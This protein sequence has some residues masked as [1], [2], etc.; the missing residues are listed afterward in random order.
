MQWPAKPR[1]AVRF[2]SWPPLEVVATFARKF[3]IKHSCATKRI[4]RVGLSAVWLSSEIV[5]RYAGSAD[6][7]KERDDPTGRRQALGI[8]RHINNEGGQDVGKF[9]TGMMSGLLAV[10]TAIGL[11]API[12]AQVATTSITGG[13]SQTTLPEGTSG[14][15]VLGAAGIGFAGG[16]IIVDGTLNVVSPG[17]QSPTVTLTLYDVGSESHWVNQIRLGNTTGAV[18]TDDD[19]HQREGGG[20]TGPFT[21]AP[22]ARI[23]TVTQGAGVAELEFWGSELPP[24]TLIVE[25]G[26][27]PKQTTGDQPTSIALAYLNDSYQIVAGPTERIL[28][29]LEDGGADRDYDDYVGILEVAAGSSAPWGTVGLR[30]EARPVSQ[31]I[32]AFVSVTAANGL[33]ISGLTAADITLLADGSALSSPPTLVLP[34]AQSSEHLSVVFAMDYSGSVAPATRQAMEAAVIDFISSMEVGDYA[35]IVKS[36]V[37]NPGKASVVQPFTAIAAD[38]QVLIDA[39]EAEYPGVGTNLYDAVILAVQ[40]FSVS[41][42][43]LPSGPKAVIVLSDGLDN[44]STVDVNAALLAANNASIPL[45]TVGVGETGNTN[46]PILTQLAGE[47]SGAYFPA[48]TNGHIADASDAVFN[49]LNNEYLLTFPSLA[50]QDCDTHLLEARVNNGG[51]TAS[52]IQAF[53][54][55]TPLLVPDLA[56]QTLAAATTLLSNAGLAL[57]SQTQETS[58]TVPAGSV[59]RHSPVAGTEVVP[60]SSVNLVLS[61]GPPPGTVPNVV[62]LTQAA[63]TTAITNASLVVGAVTQQSSTS[64]AAGNVISQSVAPGQVLTAGSAV[65]LVVSNGPPLVAVPTV[66]GLTQAAATS[67]ITGASLVAGTI[68]QESSATVPSGSVISQTPSAGTQ[69]AVGSAVNLVVSS[70]PPAAPPTPPP[71]SGGSGGGGG[72]VDHFA[73]LMLLLLAGIGRGL[74]RRREPSVQSLS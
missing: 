42:G 1:T 57:G 9:P 26:D 27:S 33:P 12:Q 34:P 2:R 15:S 62:G 18:L 13:T 35:A 69:A 73:L 70:G 22:F 47:T 21:H 64:V 6:R 16:Q 65:D 51:D 31:P 46:E 50:P 63:A 17:A 49:R 61:S 24:A 43:S 56:K 60:G 28:V 5:L 37:T 71:A 55:C 67:A 10:V 20:I 52:A 8:G 44:Q 7:Y 74:A 11:A 54:R 41:G 14:N 25:N 32:Q 3:S 30:V 36:N 58:A 40:Q 48:P 38:N 72:A 66:T 68:T 4:A 19:D 23:G 29:M 53:V 39:V 59:I 45:F